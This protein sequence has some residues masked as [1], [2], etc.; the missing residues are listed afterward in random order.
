MRVFLFCL[1]VL[2]ASG[3]ETI[4]FYGQAI[5]GQLSILAKRQD[6]DRVLRDEASDLALK[7]RLKLV[8]AIR[9]FASESLAL[10]VGKNYSS[11]VDLR[12][13]TKDN[14]VVWNVF[15]APELSLEPQVWCYPL[16]GCAHYRGYFTRQAAEGFAE[17]LQGQ[18]L[19]TY[20]GAVK[21]YSTLGWFADPVLSTFVYFDDTRLAA[22]LFHELAHKIVYIRDDTEFNESFASAVEAEA[23][24]RWL[25]GRQQLN[26]L[27]QHAM[28]QVARTQFVER[29]S[30]LRIE[31]NRLYAA[32]DL[33]RKEKLEQKHE[34]FARQQHEGQQMHV[35]G[36]RRWLQQLNNNASLVPVHSY[37]RWQSAFAQLLLQHGGDLPAFFTAVKEL[38]NLPLAR[39][40]RELQKLTDKQAQAVQKL[41]NE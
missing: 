22:L 30:V 18:G 5:S 8:Q 24:T 35:P 33:S 25:R 15:A 2:F 23:L 29:V 40:Q 13:D 6:I 20:I 36:F 4:G 26:S 16:I 14:F 11:Y 39:R 9:H 31:L 19:D 10:P 41:T 1:C 12:R 38:G 28:H 21:A 37:N 3:C 32:A 7:E 34:L 17:T 27:N